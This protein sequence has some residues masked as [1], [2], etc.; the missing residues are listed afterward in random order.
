MRWSPGTALKKRTRW[1]RYP[2]EEEAPIGASSNI[3]AT[4]SL[5]RLA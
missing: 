2:N 3:V 1:V 5:A 4:H